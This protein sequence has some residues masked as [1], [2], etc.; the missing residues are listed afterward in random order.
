[1]DTPQVTIRL[2]DRHRTMIEEVQVA[3]A[4]PLLPALNTADIL[5][6]G[7]RSLHSSVVNASASSAQ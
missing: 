1:M 7:I 4:S 3:L 6:A 5:R 2:D